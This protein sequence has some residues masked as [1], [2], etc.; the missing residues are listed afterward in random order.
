MAS[1]KINKISVKSVH[2]L[3]E[4]KVT[5]NVTNVVEKRTKMLGFVLKLHATGPVPVV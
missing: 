4:A 5:N 2:F 1:S 3:S